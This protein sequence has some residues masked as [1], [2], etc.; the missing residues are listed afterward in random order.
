MKNQIRLMGLLYDNPNRKFS[1]AELSVLLMLKLPSSG[2][3]LINRT[4]TTG[5][6]INKAKVG[7]VTYYQF[8]GM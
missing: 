1:G 8:G 5:V 7:Y 3:R 2:M 4:I 6:N